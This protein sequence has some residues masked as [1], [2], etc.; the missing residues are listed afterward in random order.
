MQLIRKILFNSKWKIGFSI[1]LIIFFSHA[2]AQIRVPRPTR[3]IGTGQLPDFNPGKSTDTIGFEHRND[4]ADSITISFRYL[5]SLSNSYLDSSI[6]DYGRYFTV[7]TGYQTIG[8]NGNAAY[9]ILFSPITKAG[10]DPGFHAFDVYKYTIENTR[11]FQ[12]TRPY[13]SLSYLLASGKEQVIKILHTQNIKPNWNAGLEYRLISTPGVFQNQNVS[14]NN[15]RFFSNYQGR[16]KRYAAYLV[17]LANKL[18]SAENGGIT[19]RSYLED[20]TRKRRVAVPVQLGD[21]IASSLA[22]F[23][24]NMA[25]G[26]IY[27]DFDLLLRQSYDIGKKDSLRINDST[28]EYLFYPKLRFQHTLNYKTTSNQFIDRLPFFNVAQNDSIFYQD[29]YSITIVPN[30]NNFF[31]LDEWKFVSNDF[32]LKQFP[33]TKNQRQ[34]IEAGLRLENFSGA[35]S[36]SVIPNSILVVYPEPPVKKSYFNAAVHG[37]YRNKTKNQKW[38][39]LL[40]GELYAAGF[41]AGDYKVYGSVERFLNSKW[42]GIKVSFQNINRNPSYIFQQN[43]AFD[44][45]TNSLTK[46]ENIT[47]F[48]FQASNPRFQLMARNISIANYVYLSDFYHTDQYGGL[49]NLTQGTL[50]FEN[51]VVG[52]VNLYSDFI[53]QLTAGKSPVHVP[54]FYTR[55]RLAFE[56]NFYKNLNLSAG[57]DITYNTPYKMDNYSP[58]MGKFFPQDTATIHNLPV[59]NAFFDF[60][61]KSFKAFIRAENL[62]TAE[63]N[64]GLMFTNNNFAAPL[65]P[66]PGFLMRF[67]IVWNFVN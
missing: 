54:L 51:K 32:A 45:D 9:P 50:S 58:I 49:I 59:V 25:I 48:T 60:R 21:S 43:S 41:S 22:L 55:Q 61:I 15:Y 46:K 35:F 31:F 13:T 18:T 63:V 20:P 37:E 17:V 53:V 40:K 16:K 67:G 24:T 64:G 7:P 1:L 10:W 65:Y 12:T 3:P 27:K 38:D 52:H 66:T 57:L 62:N 29:N 8:V 56:G 11:F 14:H 42:G 2:N 6:N 19:S 26:N 4:L 36:K 39:A 44:L 23:S 47:I 5:D 33:Q 30:A 28:M 34:F